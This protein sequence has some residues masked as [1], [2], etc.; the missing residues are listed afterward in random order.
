MVNKRTN[1]VRSNNCGF[2]LIELLLVV[3]VIGLMLAVIAPRGQRALIDSKYS[4][5]R[6]NCGELASAATTWAE[7]EMASQD[8]MIPKGSDATGNLAS[9]ADYYGWLSGDEGA[10]TISAENFTH[11]GNT[12][13]RWQTVAAV[14]TTGRFIGAAAAPPSGVPINYS[15]R[16]K[17]LINPFTGLNVFDGGNYN[18]TGAI[19]GAIAFDVAADASTATPGG[20]T[21]WVYSALVYQGTE[22]NTADGMHGSMNVN[23]L[24]GLRNG[25]FVS[26]ALNL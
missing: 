20:T 9:L 23:D 21:A 12:A 6:Q 13:G 1:L 14:N 17:Q 4:L 25:V 3:V 8:D 19:P 7:S 16:E 18:A 22:N 26:K 24:A 5:V 10:D 15:I 11:V 2:T